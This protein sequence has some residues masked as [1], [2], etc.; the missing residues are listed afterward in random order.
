MFEGHRPHLRLIVAADLQREPLH[1]FIDDP[2][3]LPDTVLH[4]P[5]VGQLSEGPKDGHPRLSPVALEH[6]IRGVRSDHDI[7]PLHLVPA[8]HIEGYALPGR[9]QLAAQVA[10]NEFVIPA[11][12]AV[13]V[14]LEVEERPRAFIDD[15]FLARRREAGRIPHGIRDA[16]L[17]YGRLR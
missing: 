9:R 5:R 13:L 6:S 16:E 2:L 17:I 11:V 12:D 1:R 10:P 7:P 3:D 8:P 15:E 4:E 14:V